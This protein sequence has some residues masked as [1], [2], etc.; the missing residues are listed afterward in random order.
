MTAAYQSQRG[1]SK[2]VACSRKHRATNA[3]RLFGRCGTP[4][5]KVNGAAGAAGA[6]H[7]SVT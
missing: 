5:E 1:G 3:E 4:Q 7:D 6:A 2:N